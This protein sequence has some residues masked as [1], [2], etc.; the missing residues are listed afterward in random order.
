MVCGAPFIST[1]YSSV[2]NFA[3]PVGKNQI[4]RIHRVHDLHGRKALGLQ[5]L[6][7]QI[8]GNLPLFTAIRE[9][10]AAPCTVANCV[11]MKLFPKSKMACSLRLSLVKPI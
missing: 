4:L 5:R 3:V 6:R 10:S 1:L 2:P 7:I 9:G 8:H 11:R